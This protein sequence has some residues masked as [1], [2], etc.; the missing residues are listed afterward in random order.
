[1]K[2]AF[3]AGLMALFF[4][5]CSQHEKFPEFVTRKVSPEEVELTVDA[6]LP[7]AGNTADSG[8]EESNYPKLDSL[9]TFQQMYLQENEAFDLERFRRVWESFRAETKNN[10]LP[11]KEAFR[12]FRVSGFLFQLTGD[13]A[14]VDEMEKIIWSQRSDATQTE[15]WDS[16]FTPYVF[17]RNVDDIHVNLFLP[18]EI[19]FTH[20]MGGKVKIRQEADFPASGSIRLN[21]SMEIKRYM[22]VFIRIPRWAEDASVTVKQ[23]KYFAPPGSFCKIAKKWKEDDVVEIEF[24]QENMPGYLAQ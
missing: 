20:S 5:S 18:G 13:A 4:T 8:R 19:G 22:E 3:L 7:S 23:V 24:S 16:I 11:E 10:R 17:T 9:L 6:D 2:Q 14:V 12:W 1:M 21:F 15:V